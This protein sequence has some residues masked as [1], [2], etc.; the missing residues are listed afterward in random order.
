MVRSKTIPD[1]KKALRH[2]TQ[3]QLA[4]FF[5]YTSFTATPRYGARNI[6][7]MGCKY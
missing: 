4:Y 5:A 2:V 7:R 6:G 3:I 1:I